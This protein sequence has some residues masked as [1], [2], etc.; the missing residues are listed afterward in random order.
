MVSR[1]LSLSL[2]GYYD[3]FP[4]RQQPRDLYRILKMCKESENNK[5]F[6]YERITKLMFQRFF[7]KKI[8]FFFIELNNEFCVCVWMDQPIIKLRNVN[9]ILKN[10]K[11]NK[12]VSQ[13][14]EKE[15]DC[16]NLKYPPT[17]TTTTKNKKQKENSIYS[18]QIFSGY[19]IE[20]V[21][22]QQT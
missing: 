21:F 2:S 15:K 1:S 6:P 20:C 4:K 3:N 17:T 13:E 19:K 9:E 14:S 16:S 5:E 10:K 8:F 7:H 11:K 18:R 22:V 12:L